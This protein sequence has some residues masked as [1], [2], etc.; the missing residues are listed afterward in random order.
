M[1]DAGSSLPEAPFVVRTAHLADIPALEALI[2]ASARGL[3]ANDY[4][5]AQIEAALGTAWGVDSELIRDGTYF[6]VEAG[7]ALVACGGWSRRQTLFGANRHAGR[8][9][10][11]LD[12]ARDAARVRAFFVH[13]GWARRGIGRL[14]LARCEE[15]ARAAGFRRAALLATLPGHRLYRA[16]GYAGD[17]VERHPLPGG[18]AIDFIPMH[19]TLG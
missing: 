17:A 8:A 9:S 15:A 4:R 7:G 19:K 10:A 11:R 5:S 6:A 12:P 1:I 18:L 2:A 14:L 3:A 13:P 16:C